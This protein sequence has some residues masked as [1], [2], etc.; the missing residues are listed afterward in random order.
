MDLY[1][2]NVWCNTEG[3]YVQTWGQTAPTVCPNNNE[4]SI[5]EDKTWITD[6]ILGAPVTDHAS[7]KTRVHQT[8]R[9]LGMKTY[10]TGSGD[11]PS[12][13]TDVGSG[14]DFHF[15]HIIGDSTNDSIYLDF[16]CIENE[17]WLHEGYI[18]WKYAEFDEISMIA[19]PRVVEWQSG[20]GTDYNLYGG[21][22]VIPSD[23]TNG[24]VE[25][26]GDLTESIGGLVYM[27]DDDAGNAPVAFWNAD[28]NTTTKEFENIIPAPY[29]NGRYNIFAYEV[30]LSNFVNR[31]PLLGDGFKRLQA[32]DVDQLGHG[33]RLKAIIKTYISDHHDDHHWHV[34]CVL[35]FHREHCV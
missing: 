8:S 9:Q 7:G 35:T 27:P 34:A 6:T 29:G 13:V 26:T 28:W 30:T 22:L 11:D 32:S 16:N 19:V 33:M 31:I 18:I 2:Y 24:T 23:G 25:I 1:K 15:D 21:Y 10:F 3:I 17:T 5:N 4:H 14:H 12:D 20:S